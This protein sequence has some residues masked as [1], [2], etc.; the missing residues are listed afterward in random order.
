MPVELACEARRILVIDDNDAIHN[1]FRKTLELAVPPSAKLTSAK[2]ALFGQSA[3]ATET[4]RQ[5]P[6]FEIQSAMQGQQGLAMVQEALRA[7]NPF[8]VAFVDMRMPPGWDGVQTIERLWQADP[9]VQVVI[10]TAYSD[11]SWEEISKKLGLTDRLLILKKPF[12][13]AEIIQIATSLSEKWSLAVK[14]QLKMDQL[15]H[16]VAE[17]TAELAHTALH[18]KLTGL[19]NRA[20]L[21]DRLAQAIQRHKRNPEYNFAV[22]FLDFDRF[23]LVND[24]LGHEV[25]DELLVAISQRLVKTMRTTDSVSVSDGSTAARLG[26]DEFVI[27]AD[28]L[29]N[30]EDAGRIAERLLAALRETYVVNGHNVVSSTASIGVTTSAME[31]TDGD[32]MLRDADNAMYH[33]KAAGKARYVLFDRQMHEQISARLEMENEL[34]HAVERNELVLHYQPVISLADG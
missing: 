10:C 25:G 18:D 32:A 21:R 20:L 19:A 13:P 11:Y 16:M 27:L 24:S 2:A 30:V 5:M 34:R 28:D 14:A 12:D 3:I 26:G 17:R 15:E 23:K 9:N 33:A 1:D 7:G 31:Y 22:F 6:E 4:R 29:K 8:V